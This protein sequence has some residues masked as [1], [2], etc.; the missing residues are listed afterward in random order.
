MSVALDVSCYH[1]DF[2]KDDIFNFFLKNKTNT[3]FFNYF[4]LHRIK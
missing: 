1:I 4:N 3:T 2:N